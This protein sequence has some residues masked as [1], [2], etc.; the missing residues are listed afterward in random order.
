MKIVI[1]GGSG[2][3]GRALTKRLDADGHDVVVLTRRAV[4]GSTGPRYL[5][6]QPDGTAP[7]PE[8]GQAT[9]WAREIESADAV[10]NLAAE[11]IADRRWTAKRKQ[12]LLDSRR[13]STRSLIAAIRAGSKRPAV[14]VQNCGIGYYGLTGDEILDES[15]PPGS[16]FLARVCVDWE[17]E[18]RAAEALGCRLVILRTGVVLARDGGA[19]KRML[20]AFQFFVGGPI[21][22]GRQYFS[23]IVREDWIDLVAWA[24]RTPA[25]AG[26]INATSPEPVTN[27]V[28]ARALGRALHR[29]S[30]MTVPGF[31]LKILFGEIAEA[32]LINGQRVVPKRTESLGFT[33][34]YSNIDAAL[35]RAVRPAP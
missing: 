17:A 4:A 25:V 18:A 30:A 6:W 21:A 26:A 22:S 5:G 7:P 14:F 19:L 9:G 10:V 3:L 31:V 23:W 12:A 29:P 11:G 35:T 1:A 24:L 27:A 28:F 33:F 16:D 34:T 20:P 8:A 2:F 15:S 13:L 32:G